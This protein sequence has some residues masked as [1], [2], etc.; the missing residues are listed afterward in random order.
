MRATYVWIPWFIEGD[1]NKPIYPM[2]KKGGIG[3]FSKSMKEFENFLNLNGLMDTLVLG[4][5]NTLG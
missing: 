4:N 1:F 5:S 3:N 2:N